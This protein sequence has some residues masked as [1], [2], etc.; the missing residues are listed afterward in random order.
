[1][2]AQA[3]PFVPGAPGHT[4]SLAHQPRDRCPYSG[5]EEL[6]PLAQRH[7]EANSL[8][9]EKA[10]AVAQPGPADVAVACRR[11]R[12]L[13]DLV[14]RLPN[15][16]ALTQPSPVLPDGMPLELVELIARALPMP[17]AKDVRSQAKADMLNTILK[18][19]D[20]AST[21]LLQHLKQSRMWPFWLANEWWRTKGTCLGLES[22]AQLELLRQAWELMTE[23][24]DQWYALARVT[25]S[26]AL[27]R[28][29]LL[30]QVEARCRSPQQA[31][32]NQLGTRIIEAPKD[33][34]HPQMLKD[35][36]P[37]LA[38]DVALVAHQGGVSQEVA[39]RALFENDFDIVNAIMAICFEVQEVRPA[40]TYKSGT[41]TSATRYCRKMSVD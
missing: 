21:E 16:Y 8:V 18:K 36:R 20:P 10:P 30:W 25:N 31:L 38:R 23:Q 22:S 15:T 14:R 5:A 26:P 6:R 3:A 1:M 13:R 28:A 2:R 33:H 29:R 19:L 4:L 35:P 27:R 37:Q 17:E 32:W 39:E 9:C 12:H 41:S 7:E 34:S 11:H 40:E 24:G